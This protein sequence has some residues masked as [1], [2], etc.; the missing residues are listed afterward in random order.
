LYT[1]AGNRWP[2]WRDNMKPLNYS[3]K[4]RETMHTVVF[5]VNKY[6]LYLGGSLVCAHYD[7]SVIRECI[8]QNGI[9]NVTDLSA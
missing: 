5:D 7:K 6:Y 1:H 8:T 4:D 2:H 9:L 3:Q